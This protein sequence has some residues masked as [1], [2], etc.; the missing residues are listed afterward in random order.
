MFCSQT[1]VALFSSCILILAVGCGGSGSSGSGRS[2]TDNPAPTVSLLS[3]SS[4]PQYGDPITLGIIGTGFVNSSQVLWGG[5]AVATTYSSPTNLIA[6]VPS[7]SISTIGSINVT[8]VNPAPGG[9]S[10]N[11]LP[12]AVGNPVPILASLSPAAGPAGGPTFTLT[13]TGSHFVSGSVIKWNGVNL[14]TTYVSATQLTAQVP[15]SDLIANGLSSTA[16]VTVVNP[17][18]SG[19]PSSAVPFTIVQSDAQLVKINTSAND[20]AW[21]AVHS[22]IYASL[23]STAQNGN[24]IVAID[25][26]SATVG[27]P[28]PV[29]SEPRA[30][31]L[32]DDDSFLYVGIDGNGQIERLNLPALTVDT[33]LNLQLPDYDQ[34]HQAAFA[35]A[36]APGHPHE[37]ATVMVQYHAFAFSTSF[38]GGT[39]IYDDAVE[40]P[41]VLSSNVF[42]S[43]LE[44]GE[45]ASTLYGA[46]GE[47]TGSDLFALSVNS[48]GVS[49]HAD[50][51]ALLPSS[52]FGRIHYDPNSK[53]LYAD[54]GR[55]VDPSTG[56]VIGAFN[57]FPL[58]GN[59][60][61]L[62]ALDIQNGRVFFI[63]LTW[64]QWQAGSGVTIESFDVKTYKKLGTVSIPNIKGIPINFLRWGS[65][66]LAFNV[67]DYLQRYW[68]GHLAGGPIYLLDGPFV[69]SAKTADFYSGTALASVP[70]LTSMS[71]E[72]A[73]AGAGDI[74]LTVTG[75]S[76]DAGAIVT[77][78]GTPLT[79][80]SASSTQITAKIPA[81]SLAAAGSAVISVSSTATN[82]SSVSSLAFTVAPQN[83]TS[84]LSALNVASFD[85]AWDAKDSRLIVPVFSA[86]PRYPNSIVSVDPSTGTI[87][88][89]APEL[90][91][92]DL[93]RVTDDGS[94]VYIGY[95]LVNKVASR[96]L[97]DLASYSSFG[98]G[99]GF[100]R[101]L[102]YF[103]DGP[104]KV[105]DLRPA[106]G[107]P[108]T[109][110][111]V[112]ASSDS[113]PAGREITIFDSGVARLNS[114]TARTRFQSIQWNTNGSEIYGT[115]GGT[116]LY[117]YL[118]GPSGLT[119]DSLRHVT[120]NPVYLERLHWDATTGYLYD[121]DG[122]AVNPSTGSIVGDFKASGLVVPDA[123]L[124]RVF[125]LGQLA[126]Q[127]NTSNYTVQ[128]FD[129]TTYNLVRS[130]T[131]NSLVGTPVAFVRWGTSGLALVTS[132]FDRTATKTGPA[133][134]LYILTDS[135][136]ASANASTGPTSVERVQ[137]FRR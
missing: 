32:A 129:K 90:A 130:L 114:S 121:D 37:I 113:V 44:W 54:D 15:S 38:T 1:N 108:L 27:T 60:Q 70:I 104:Y 9:G 131:L 88:K 29:G 125:I 63:G 53:Y 42:D 24:S 65:A 49:L 11:A 2:T 96:T 103:T 48:S 111:I 64:A 94:L 17:T 52:R 35:I 3:P 81:V 135:N 101:G 59:A 72:I 89:S 61:P 40:R 126:S 120:P 77:W 20:I 12:F 116:D 100:S 45:D 21:D 110:A 69:N 119:L 14:A 13:V 93:V 25:P 136:L 137:A 28:V 102:Y 74:A 97:P 123:T 134:M 4:A 95:Q 117:S 86:D 79:T 76:F 118:A 133:G 115:E 91:D 46:D 10:S 18:P 122:L 109:T 43:A 87:D 55:V 128:F 66:G 58:Q 67:S 99:S 23:P 8:V 85:L 92:P 71:P 26:A 6:Q 7:A 30:L 50:Y 98:L 5:T 62:C 78:N 124:N 22:K 57:L 127:I 75:S 132:N 73:I 34:G 47:S 112:P 31:A 107:A 39:A 68:P 105:G 16:N 51:R 80:L 84:Q 41:T 56:N 83:S 36:V 82:L 106:P 19:G 33:S